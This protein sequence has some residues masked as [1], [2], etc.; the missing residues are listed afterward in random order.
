MPSGKPNIV[1]PE[2]LEFEAALLRSVGEMQRGDFASVHTPEQILARSRGR[3]VGT[4]KASPKVATTIRL[5]A[6]VL[7]RFKATGAGWQTRMN[8]ALREWV[9]AHPAA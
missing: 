3:P 6:D 9:N 4:I 2:V 7:L 1:D 5:D 8:E